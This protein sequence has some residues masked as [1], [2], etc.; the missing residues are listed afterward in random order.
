MTETHAQALNRIESQSLETARALATERLAAMERER[1]K[2]ARERMDDEQRQL[3][4]NEKLTAMAEAAARREAAL[5]TQLETERKN[6]KQ[7]IDTLTIQ[8]QQT[9][10]Q[11]ANFE[12]QVQVTIMNLN[13]R[14]ARA[15]NALVGR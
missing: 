5:Q 2:L 4:E 1:A 7:V 11:A 10:D 3:I 12:A 6:S 14:I 15:Q 8:L 9:Q 13:D